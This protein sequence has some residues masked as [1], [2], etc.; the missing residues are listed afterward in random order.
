[1][2]ATASPTAQ[3]FMQGALLA[4]GAGTWE[5]DVLGGLVYCDP[6]MAALYDFDPEEAQRGISIAAIADKIHP[7]DRALCAVRR[8]IKIKKGGLFVNEYRVVSRRGVVRWVLV[9]GRYEADA[10]GCVF[11]ARGLV[12]DATESRLD[13]YAEGRIFFLAGAEDSE[14]ATALQSAADHALAAR[15]A[16]DQL[17]L[18]TRAA[19]R[20]FADALL[21]EIGMH[22]AVA[23]KD[24]GPAS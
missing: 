4:T 11:R 2:K 17:A 5:Y 23:A 20:P 6:V 14:A 3:R 21:L 10:T 9:R 1:M 13:G 12:I 22:L 19:L 18:P 15:K 8:A 16:I 7:D 24:G